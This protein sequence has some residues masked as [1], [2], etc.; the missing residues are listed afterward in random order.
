MTVLPHDTSQPKPDNL[1]YTDLDKD[2]NGLTYDT[3]QAKTLDEA[4]LA[5]SAEKKE[6]DDSGVIV[7]MPLEDDKEF[8]APIEKLVAAIERVKSTEEVPDDL[9]RSKYVLEQY[10]PVGYSNTFIYCHLENKQLTTCVDP[11]YPHTTLQL[12]GEIGIEW[13][14]LDS[15]IQEWK[16]NIL[17]ID[18]YGYFMTVDFFKGFRPGK[19]LDFVLDQ[20][21]SEDKCLSLTGKKDSQGRPIRKPKYN[22]KLRD[23][24]GLQ[25]GDNPGTSKPLKLPVVLTDEQG[26]EWLLAFKASEVG[27]IAGIAKLQ[28]AAN[29]A[30]IPMP[31]KNVIAH[32]KFERNGVE[33]DKE[34]DQCYEMVSGCNLVMQSNSEYNTGSAYLDLEKV[35]TTAINNREESVKEL[36]SLK[37]KSKVYSRSK[38]IET[39][40]DI[41]IRDHL[42][43]LGRWLIYG[44]ND[45][46]CHE[47]L[48]GF[49]TKANQLN[50]GLGNER[51]LIRPTVGSTVKGI[52]KQAYCREA[53]RHAGNINNDSVLDKVLED[54]LVKPVTSNGIGKKQ[55]SQS[56]KGNEDTTAMLCRKVAGGYIANNRPLYLASAVSL[57]K[58]A[59]A[60]VDVA[61]A[62]A[63]CMSVQNA[64]FGKFREL[65]FDADIVEVEEFGD[66][67]PKTMLP[68]LKKSKQI[69][70]KETG[71]KRKAAPTLGWFI[72]THTKKLLLDNNALIFIEGKDAPEDISFIPSFNP[73]E[74]WQKSHITFTDPEEDDEYFDEYEYLEKPQM[75]KQIKRELKYG[76][77]TS[78]DLEKIDGMFSKT[79]KKWLLSCKVIYARWYDSKD[80]MEPS[81]FWSEFNDW[82]QAVNNND[83]KVNRLPGYVFFDDSGKLVTKDSK[84]S[85]L[86][87][88]V[89]WKHYTAHS[90]GNLFVDGVLATRK[91]MKNKR[92][93]YVPGSDDY[94]KYDGIQNYYKLVNN[95]GYGSM[96][97][98][99]L[100][101]GNT[102]SMNN[103]TSN[104]RTV[105]QMLTACCRGSQPITD[106]TK[107]DVNGVLYPYDWKR[108]E[109]KQGGINNKHVVLEENLN[110]ERLK[111]LGVKILPIGYQADKSDPLNPSGWMKFEID[112]PKVIGY[113]KDGS[114]H[115]FQPENI[116]NPESSDGEKHE[117]VK[118]L[119]GVLLPRHIK[120]CF[121]K[122]VSW[123][124]ELSFNFQTKAIFSDW[125]TIAQGH[126]CGH[127][128]ETGKLKRKMRSHDTE[129]PIVIHFFEEALLKGIKLK[130]YEN[131]HLLPVSCTYLNK[132]IAIKCGKYMKSHK[133]CEKARLIPGDPLVTIKTFRAFT[134][135]QFNYQTWEQMNC[136]ISNHNR[137]STRYGFSFEKY[138]IVGE[139]EIPEKKEEGCKK[140]ETYT[141]QRTYLVDY[142]AMLEHY[143]Q[144][145]NEGYKSYAQYAKDKHLKLSSLIKNGKSVNKNNLVNLYKEGL[146]KRIKDVYTTVSTARRYYSESC[147]DTCAQSLSANRA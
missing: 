100:D 69:V 107:I 44:G 61:G 19:L 36:I 144:L 86:K 32:N 49:Q 62:Y 139:Y 14:W 90:L 74:N 53:N 9:K 33:F 67:D 39:E 122:M 83:G 102:V 26:R 147:R 111:E 104:I 52:I 68:R 3:F 5:A 18:F 135:S 124:N 63:G 142:G 110:D 89:H 48:K 55:S 75:V 129:N 24:K 131:K 43:D 134:P 35:V 96:A 54:N 72:K 106:G 38:Q 66:V 145:I 15:E 22:L 118:Y 140:E 126:Y 59:N 57:L 103:V 112:G 77:L 27:K 113:Q 95:T 47:I 132:N 114:K 128:I 109:I 29:I 85:K 130:G 115:F 12:L 4:Y 50:D 123:F 37:D 64:Y 116:D 46:V 138:F 17:V 8:S 78:G 133:F 28:D 82:A 65:K 93:E 1:F 60:D 105:V 51:S 99:F 141:K 81:I 41:F 146:T 70:I 84:G 80:Y 91:Q 94:Q 21:K 125:A 92:G 23:S 136:L 73:P 101:I 30:G 25:Y 40:F 2:D 56:I 31:F 71:N 58:P 76:I 127:Q 11:N 7:Y 42:T 97:S 98:R 120:L 79:M 45:N 6:D 88:P 20:V 108:L 87:P 10:K 137:D 119:D 16:G 34:I 117:F 143:Q 13:K 121:P